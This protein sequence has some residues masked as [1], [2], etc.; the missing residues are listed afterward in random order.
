[1][2]QNPKFAFYSVIVDPCATHVEV[3]GVRWNLYADYEP[4][5]RYLPQNQYV[6]R[7]THGQLCEA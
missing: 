2:G 3:A 5:W 6:V 4:G 1:M 7:P